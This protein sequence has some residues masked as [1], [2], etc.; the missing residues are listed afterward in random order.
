MTALHSQSRSH[1]GNPGSTYADQRVDVD[2]LYRKL[3]WRIIPLILLC[4]FFGYLD[5]VNVGF[6]KLEMVSDLGLSEA[7]YGVGAGLFF[8]GYLLLQVPAGF[9][10]QRVGDGVALPDFHYEPQ[11][12]QK[13]G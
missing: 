4:Y 8:L 2:V 13:A 1:A 5:R 11:E 3:T 9:L 6:A 10:V 12:Q 7:A